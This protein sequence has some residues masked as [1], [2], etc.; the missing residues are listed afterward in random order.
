MSAASSHTEPGR[1]GAMRA[2]RRASV[3]SGPKLRN[4]FTSS[5]AGQSILDEELSACRKR[6]PRFGRVGLDQTVAPWPRFQRGAFNAALTETSRRLRL[7]VMPSSTNRKSR[8]RRRP[9]EVRDAI[10]LNACARPHSTLVE[11][12]HSP[13]N[14][15]CRLGTVMFVLS[16]APHYRSS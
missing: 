10:I 4:N 1:L 16:F 15:N 3:A 7:P 8:N 9:G 14:Q 11:N 13:P 2:K 5:R 6:F 12:P